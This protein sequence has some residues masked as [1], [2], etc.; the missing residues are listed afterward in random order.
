MT[1][2]IKNYSVALNLMTEIKDQL[3]E[4][5]LSRMDNEFDKTLQEP[6]HKLRSKMVKQHK[7]NVDDVTPVCQEIYPMQVRMTQIETNLEFVLENAC[8]NKSYFAVARYFAEYDFLSQQIKKEANKAKNNTVLQ[9]FLKRSTVLETNWFETMSATLAMMQHLV[10]HRMNYQPEIYI[11]LDVI[12]D[13][14]LDFEEVK[15]EYKN[16]LKKLKEDLKKQKK[17]V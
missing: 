6:D 16:T 13:S 1:H 3:S 11:D 7:R 15:V 9:D 17:V 5:L 10:I 4:N 12:Q 2:D 14:N 8:Y